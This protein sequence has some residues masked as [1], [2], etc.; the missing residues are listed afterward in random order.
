MSG[1]GWNGEPRSALAVVGDTF[2][3]Y[4][5]HPLLFFV[6]AAGVLVPYEAILVA[7][8]GSG[9]SGQAGGISFLLTIVDFGF[10][11][12]LVSALHVHAVADVR[13][14]EQPRIAAV[15]RRGL[16]VLPVVAAASIAATLGMIGGFILL[17]VPGVILWL[18]W[19]VAAQAAAIENEGWQPALR[20]S[21]LLV[22]ANYLHVLGVLLCVMAIGI[23]GV[24]VNLAF[25]MHSTAPAALLAGLAIRI[26]LASISALV[27]AVLYY[28]LRG[29]LTA[30]LAAASVPEVESSQTSSAGAQ[31]V[32]G[33][34]R[35]CTRV[36]RSAQLR[37]RGAA[38]RLVRRPRVP[39]S[40]ALLGRAGSRRL[41][42]LGADAAQDAASLGSRSG[43]PDRV[44]AGLG[45]LDWDV[46]R[47]RALGRDGGSLLETR[48]VAGDEAGGRG[49]GEV[50]AGAG[51]LR[52]ADRVPA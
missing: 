24:L 31:L 49:R 46:D 9:P 4:V 1:R 30:R 11:T 26:L 33:C 39:A 41:G 34:D 21:A 32:V 50:P 27:G 48:R 35:T 42:R 8:T 43:D 10:I 25:G 14:G 6:L 17:V 51:P 36:L 19:F 44:L 40:D 28:E 13:E 2:R 18:R 23:P 45:G 15:A 29:R 52:V 12:P 7:M 38:A 3:L 20:R 47:R 22:S 5:S 16:S 37:R